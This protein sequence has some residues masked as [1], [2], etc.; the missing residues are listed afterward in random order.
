RSLRPGS[1]QPARSPIGRGGR[2]AVERIIGGVSGVAAS[3][4]GPSAAERPAPRVLRPRRAD[5]RH[6]QR[7]RRRSAEAAPGAEGGGLAA[8]AVIL[9]L[10]ALLLFGLGLAGG[11]CASKRQ[12]VV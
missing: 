5:G 11:G 1:R 9:V 7:Q 10:M 4:A 2:M 12:A 8:R 6:S 3:E